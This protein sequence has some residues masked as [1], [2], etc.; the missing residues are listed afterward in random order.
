MKIAAPARRHRRLALAP[1]I[2]VVFLLM[3]FFML[4]A[5]FGAEAVLPLMPG[6][7]AAGAGWSGP[8][9]LIDIRPG[10]LALNGAETDLAALPGRLAPLMADPGDPVVLR[11]RDGADVQR[12]VDVAGALRAAGIGTLLVVEAAPQ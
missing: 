9:R 7:T 4:A 5:R 2:D 11:P 6:G 1:M 10:G 12:L 3:V 8:P